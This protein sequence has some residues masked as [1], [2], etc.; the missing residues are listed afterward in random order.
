MKINT[1]KIELLAAKR[2]M[3][4]TELA[5]A[6]EMTNQNS[7]RFAA[8]AAA[9][10]LPLYALPAPCT[11]SRRKSSRKGAKIC[12]FGGTVP[13]G[14]TGIYPHPSKPPLLP[15]FRR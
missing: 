2:G 7:T 8:G 5:Q 13:A 12:I 6:M 11:V 9:R 10:Q 1:Q 4:V 15:I 14:Y 3:T